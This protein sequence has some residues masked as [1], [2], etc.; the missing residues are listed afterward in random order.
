MLVAIWYLFLAAYSGMAIRG[1]VTE[2]IEEKKT[3]KDGSPPFESAGF[4]N[5]WPG[6][7]TAEPVQAYGGIKKSPTKQS[8][9]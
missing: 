7:A 1:H 9:S 3:W 6:A 8:A 5:T 2:K 4:S